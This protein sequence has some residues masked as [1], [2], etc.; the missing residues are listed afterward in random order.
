MAKF[1]LFDA[2]GKKLDF[3][4]KIFEL[5][6][7]QMAWV[8][9][10]SRQDF[11]RKDLASK[12]FSSEKIDQLVELK[13]QQD[14][15]FAKE[16]SL[17]GRAASAVWQ[18]FQTAWESLATEKTLVEKWLSA[19]KDVVSL[20]FDIVWAAA[21]PVI[22]PAIE[23]VTEYAPEF[24]KEWARKIGEAYGELSPRTRQNIEAITWLGTAAVWA[25]K[26]P[27]IA[28]KTWQVAAKTGQ[29]VKTGIVSAVKVPW[30]AIEAWVE[31]ITRDIP[32]KIVRRELKFSPTESARIENIT[33]VDEGTYILQKW[34]AWKS[35]EELAEHFMRQSDDM[36]NGITKNLAKVE[37]RVKSEDA[38]EALL[39][40]IEQME[41]STKIKRAYSDDIQAAKNMLSR[42]DYSLS[43]LNNIRR[44]YDKVNTGMFTVEG[45]AR[46][47]LENAIDVRVRQR[48]SETLQKEAKKAGVDVK[49]MNKELRAWI[50]M[51][52][53]L[54][55]SLSKEER[56]NL[57]GLQDIGIGAILAGG[58]PVSA[59]A[60]IVGKKYIEWVAPKA[61]QKLY[62][63]SK[64][65]N[66]P[67]TVSRGTTITPRD[68]SSRL[69]LVSNTPA[70]MVSKPVKKK[71]RPE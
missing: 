64:K 8:Q 22:T 30:K 1:N 6:Q 61:A 2:I 13:K 28:A 17:L 35:K 58:E 63:L 32:K 71:K 66:V 53:A 23:T 25:V 27:A 67:R 48:L 16:T 40:M 43:E 37:K 26:A 19:A 49:E 31:T 60:T 45:K 46:S 68:K 20:P 57:I 9:A 12:G 33:W 3:W 44:A 54:L 47:G 70:P 62:S 24:V 69:G 7:E 41:S 15:T 38:R 10:E 56:N 11:M 39:D 21:A 65:P 5:E 18:R 59:V 42:D 14:P 52:D 36:Y 29:A 51:K 55:R 34:L 50:E 4:E